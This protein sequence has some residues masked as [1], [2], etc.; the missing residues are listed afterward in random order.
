MGTITHEELLKR[1]EE[2]ERNPE[3]YKERPKGS[4]EKLADCWGKLMNPNYQIRDEWHDLCINTDF[5]LKEIATKLK[6][7]Y[8]WSD[9]CHCEKCKAVKNMTANE[10]KR[11]IERTMERLYASGKIPKL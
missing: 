8:F 7:S 9:S 2:R 1:L 6:K 10:E 4:F 3:K 11:L 5:S